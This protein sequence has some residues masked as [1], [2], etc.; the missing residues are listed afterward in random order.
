MG[1]GRALKFKGSFAGVSKTKWKPDK[2][3]ASHHDVGGQHLYLFRD[4]LA[5]AER[6]VFSR[7]ECEVKG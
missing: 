6:L 5:S 7:I 2:L 1:N 4:G 3:L